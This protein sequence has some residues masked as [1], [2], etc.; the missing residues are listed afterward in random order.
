MVPFK[1][2]GYCDESEDV[3]SLVITCVFA[4]AADWALIVRPWQA[5]LNEYEIPELA[6]SE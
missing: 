2:V 1:L 6:G 5:L 4:R 3:T